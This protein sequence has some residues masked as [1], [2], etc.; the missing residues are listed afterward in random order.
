MFSWGSRVLISPSRRSAIRRVPLIGAPVGA[1]SDGPGAGTSSPRDRR[2]SDHTTEP[3]P[4]AMASTRPK[5]F[6]CDTRALME[7]RLA[8][9]RSSGRPDRAVVNEHSTRTWNEAPAGT[10]TSRQ[11]LEGMLPVVAKEAGDAPQ[12]AQRL[13]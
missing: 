10:T 6:D 1:G 9:F 7:R 2:P 12:D 4:A 3:I 11:H 13:D 8:G 5:R